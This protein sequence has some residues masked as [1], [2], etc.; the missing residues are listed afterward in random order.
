MLCIGFVLSNRSGLPN[1]RH[2]I[3]AV[4]VV[5][6]IAAAFALGDLVPGV[7]AGL[8][9]MALGVLA[10]PVMH[11][12]PGGVAAGRFGARSLLR[13][14]V[15]LLG[16]RIAA[17]DLLSLGVTGLALALATVAAT[18]VLTVWLR[19][20]LGV[21]SQLVLLI[22]AGSA[23][24]GASAVARRPRRSTPTRSR[25]A[26]LCSSMKALTSAG[27]RRALGENVDAALRISLASHTSRSSAFRRSRSS[28]VRRSRRVP[29]SASAWRPTAATSRGA[30]QVRGDI[31]DR[32]AGIEHQTDRALTQVIVMLPRGGHRAADVGQA[33]PT[34]DDEARG[35][36][37]ARSPISRVPWLKRGYL[38]LR[39]CSRSH[40]ALLPERPQMVPTF[41]RS[42]ATGAVA[43]RSVLAIRC[44]SAAVLAVFP[45][46]LRE[47]E[48][49]RETPYGSQHD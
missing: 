10:A 19:R 4:A 34:A 18:L 47:R 26:A 24:C 48:R 5:A 25:S 15:A 42:C 49:E 31:R 23:I 28:A 16:L 29:A 2:L 11:R 45:R 38:P 12:L 17:G 35:P 13:V 14:G 32:T 40:G 39:C 36:I 7:A 20:R 41:R 43:A 33:D 44:T 27:S 37:K 3:G 21:A 6:L 8:W 9:A 22:G 30:R 46:T 1:P